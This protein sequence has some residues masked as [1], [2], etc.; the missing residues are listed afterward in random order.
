MKVGVI[1][2]GAVG[3]AT[4]MAI[5]LRER[6]RT[7]ICNST[8]ATAYPPKASVTGGCRAE[9]GHFRKSDASS[10]V[11]HPTCHRHH[12]TKRLKGRTALRRDYQCA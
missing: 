6:P 8:N 11:H 7:E 4:A 2:V 10:Q 12:Q 9:L 3:V 5:A 1:G